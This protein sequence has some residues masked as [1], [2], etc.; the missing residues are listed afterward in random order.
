MKRNLLTSLVMVSFVL[1]LPRPTV[2][3]QQSESSREQQLEELIRQLSDKVQ[4]L[5]ARVNEL[6]QGKADRATEERVQELATN[7]EQI[8]QQQP[9]ADAEEWAKLRQWVTDSKTLRPYWKDGLRLDSND[10]SVELKIGGRIQN[11]WAYFVE[12]GDLERRRGV[13]FDDGTEFRR[14]RLYISGT[15]YDDLEFVAQY[16]FAGGD[17]DFKDVYMG[18]KNVPYVGRVRVGQFKEPFSL[19]ELTS[20]NYITFMERS[21]VNTFAPSR[22]VGVMAMNTMLDKRMTWAVGVFRQTDDFGNGSGGRDYNVTGRLT[23]LPWYEEDGRKLLHVGLAYTHQNYDDDE[24]RIRSRPESHLAPNLVDTGTF[25]AEYGDL[26]GT[27]AALV[28]G[29]FSLQAE[30]VHSFIEG[31]THFVGDST[32]CAAS[33][34]ASYFLTGEHRPY[35]TSSAAFDRVRPKENFT[36]DGGSGAWELA[37]RYSYLDLNDGP[38]R[39]GRLDDFTLGVNWYLNPNARVMWNYVFANPSEGGDANMFQWRFQLAF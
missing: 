10:G 14:A 3:A 18:L 27:E 4:A 24:F 15:I 6:E 36:P 20:S 37:A 23:G 13:D 11:D 22:N 25:P 2:L 9:P 30:Y 12:D 7:V 31:R 16:D 5:E 8:R 28:Y 32:F 26:I 39:G 33:V 34:Q 38:V 19:E 29:P 17:A 35:S 21:L 1:G